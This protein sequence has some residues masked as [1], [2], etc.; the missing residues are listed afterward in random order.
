M[1]LHLH[2]SVDNS[3]ICLGIQPQ[4]T[5]V[6]KL[7]PTGSRT[8]AKQGS[9]TEDFVPCILCSKTQCNRLASE[10]VNGSACLTLPGQSSTSAPKHLLLTV[11]SCSAGR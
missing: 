9:A 2:V 11:K 6:E 1:I 10:T 3:P 8:D 5:P 4:V 7:T